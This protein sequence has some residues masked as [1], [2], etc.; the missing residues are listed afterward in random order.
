MPRAKYNEDVLTLDDESF[1][2]SDTY[3]LFDDEVAF[4][5]DTNLDNLIAE[6]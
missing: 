6:K 3:S 2:D 5:T 1:S 4:D